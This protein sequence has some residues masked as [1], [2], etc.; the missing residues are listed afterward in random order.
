MQ[1][2][3]WVE[4]YRPTTIEECILP[5]QLKKDFEQILKQKELQNM[6]LTGT[7]GTGK[8]TVAKAMCKE[9]NL[10]YILNITNPNLF[11]NFTNYF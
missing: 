7:A 8:T 10:D 1:E 3:L 9:L 4:K 6:L 11:Q 2:H 5:S